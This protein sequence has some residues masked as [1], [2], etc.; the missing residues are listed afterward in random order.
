MKLNLIYE[1]ILV[2]ARKEMNFAGRWVHSICILYENGS[3]GRVVCELLSTQNVGP[4][5]INQI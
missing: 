5:I 4:S 2:L 3:M 1:L